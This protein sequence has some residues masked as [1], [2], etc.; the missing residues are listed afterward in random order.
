MEKTGK[1]GMRKY[2]VWIRAAVRSGKASL[3]LFPLTQLSVWFGSLYM[4]MLFSVELPE[5]GMFF[6]ISLGSGAF[7]TEALLRMMG[8][9]RIRDPF[10]SLLYLVCGLHG[11]LFTWILSLEE[12]GMI[13]GMEAE[14]LQAYMGRYA[15]CYFPILYLLA[16]YCLLRQSGM[17]PEAYLVHLFSGALRT[18][19][20]YTVL[21]VGCSMVLS[22]LCSLFDVF[23]LQ[24]F[25]IIM[26]TQCL[27]FGFVF[28]SGLLRS[29]SV[30]KEPEKTDR[31][32]SILEEALIKYVLTGLVG[33]VFVIIYAYVIKILI[34]WD[35]PSNEVFPILTALFV[36]GVPVWTMNS[37]YQEKNP[38]LGVSMKMP[39][40]FFPLIFLQCYCMGIRIAGNGVTPSRYAGMAFCVFE[41]LYL[42]VYH[43]RRQRL[44]RLLLAGA[45]LVFAAALL[46]GVNMY[47]VSRNSQRS[48]LERLLEKPEEQ[49]TEDERL[50]LLGAYA[51]L[52]KDP[53]GKQYLDSLTGERKEQV[54][55]LEEGEYG[56]EETLICFTADVPPVPVDVEGFRSLYPLRENTRAEN[57]TIIDLEG[58]T[59][60]VGEDVSATFDLEGYLRPC[61]ERWRD[62]S[63]EEAEGEMDGWLQ[64]NQRI[65]LDED[66]WLQVNSLAFRY[67]LE[68]EGYVVININGYLLEK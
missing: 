39:Y 62:A 20:L 12:E 46:P 11:G 56:S 19:I 53:A 63:C 4:A 52:K 13:W 26:Q 40:L 3:A 47:A 22:I 50:R 33:C 31:R 37:R 25:E 55:L 21:V 49:L 23:F 35:M 29:L 24:D 54:R 61:L 51:Y 64:E 48:D 45:A 43:F 16:F 18:G 60:T 8:R 68:R 66:I 41:L 57:D 27:L 14:M 15:L 34:L 10:R 32:G 59:L 38:L 58:Y 9:E 30:P 17:T 28:L 65:R 1:R 7:F 44:G 36:I 42:G 67:D 2:T 5:E 6:L